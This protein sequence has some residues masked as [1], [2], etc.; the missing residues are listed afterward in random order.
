MTPIIDYPYSHH[1]LPDNLDRTRFIPEFHVAFEDV[2][3]V[4]CN[5][6]RSL[7]SDIGEIVFGDLVHFKRLERPWK[8]LEYLSRC[9]L[10]PED[11]RPYHGV[12]NACT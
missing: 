2:P 8:N 5:V 1:R 3:A 6:S 9:R 10:G 11:E 4:T 12:G 7:P